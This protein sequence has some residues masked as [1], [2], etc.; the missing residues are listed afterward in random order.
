MNHE[1]FHEF[2]TLRLYDELDPSAAAALGEH[3]TLCA[4][5]RAFARELDEGLGRLPRAGT[6]D[7]LPAGWIEELRA[8]VGAAPPLPRR[9]RRRPLLLAFATGLAAGLLAMA[10]WHALGGEAARPAPKTPALTTAFARATPP[11]RASGSGPL[12]QLAAL[13][14]RR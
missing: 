11:P 2:L 9:T 8:K 14:R 1:R 10:G 13:G 3:L 4:T 7:D 6:T 5:C 12:V